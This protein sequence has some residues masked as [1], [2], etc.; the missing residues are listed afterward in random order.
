MLSQF[1][2]PLRRAPRIASAFPRIAPQ[3]PPTSPVAALERRCQRPQRCAHAD[4]HQRRRRP[5]SLGAPRRGDAGLR[6]QPLRHASAA[7]GRLH[8]VTYPFF[9]TLHASHPPEL[10]R[11]LPRAD[12]PYSHDAS[13]LYKGEGR[14]EFLAQ[15]RR[16]EEARMRACLHLLGSKEADLFLLNV[17]IQIMFVRSPSSRF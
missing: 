12:A 1:R 13:V 10:L 6:G 9:P 7:V 11:E 16:V 15:V 2:V 17:T 5:L 14:D 3:V 8:S 4:P